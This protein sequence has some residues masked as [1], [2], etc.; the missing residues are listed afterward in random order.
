MREHWSRR[1]KA[2]L[3]FLDLPGDEMP[4]LFIHGHGCAGSHDYPQVAAHPDLA[5]HRRIL[6]DL[7]GAGYSDHSAEFGYSVTDHA[8]VLQDLVQDLD[9]D[10]LIVFGHSAGGAIALELVRRVTDRVHGLVLSESNLDPSPPGAVSYQVG[11]TTEEIF[12]GSGYRE[13]LAAASD[14][15]DRE[16]AASLSHWSP[17][18]TWRL[19]RS[20]KEGQQPNGRR[21]LYDL[22]IPRAYLIAENSLP[23]PDQ[24]ELPR[25]GVE[26]L[27]VPHAGHSMAWE[28]PAGVAAAIAAAIGPWGSSRS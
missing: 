23:D 2:F 15:D 16:W 10:P 27:T 28:N 22:Q 25:H 20:L 13:F 19:A 1:A 18:A 11:S 8:E 21:V 24:I 6:V 4:I 12:A 26:V 17:E 5:G 3:R 9:L 14:S 7:V